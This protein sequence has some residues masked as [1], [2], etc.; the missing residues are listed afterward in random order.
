MKKFYTLIICLLLVFVTGC[1]VNS[2]ANDAEYEAKIAELEEKVAGLEATINEKNAEI[3]GKDKKIN[4]LTEQL[5]KKAIK[6]TISV[7]DIDGEELANKEIIGKEGDKLVDALND[8]FDVV[9]VQTDW[10][11]SIVSIEGSIVDANYYLA[12]YENDEYATVGADQLVLENNDKIK[13][14]SECWNTDFDETDKLVDKIIYHF[15][16]NDFAGIYEKVD[17]TGKTPYYDYYLTSAVL[18]MK[19]LGYDQSIFNF[20]FENAA[21]LKEV[22]ENKDWQSETVQNNFMKGGIT[23]LALGADMANFTSALNAQTKYNYW[24][25]I[26]AKALN[27]ENDVLTSTINSWKA[28]T[29]AGDSSMMALSAYSLFMTKEELGTTAIDET[30]K[31]LTSTGVDSW[32]IN[33]ASTAQ[34]ILGLCCLGLNARTYTVSID[35]NNTTDPITILTNYAIEGGLKYQLKDEK[36]DLGYTTPQGITALLTYKVMRDLKLESANCFEYLGK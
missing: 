29:A 36:V 22:L 18:M 14:V 9:S 8:N 21:S 4:E 28:P 5:N 26:V 27:I 23:M 31:K 33:G 32:G 2:G 25:A 34:F 19:K 3:E 6:Y 7:Y 11:T 24:Q 16:K 30:Y 13:Y 10:G 12:C 15:M 20:N 1:T 17:S 35:E